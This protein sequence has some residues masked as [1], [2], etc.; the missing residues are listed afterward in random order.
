MVDNLSPEQRRRT[1]QAV[2]SRNTRLEVRLRSA[3]HAR[4]LR[5]R[6]H[7]KDL[8]GTPDLIFPRWN[9]VVFV[10][11]CFWHGHQCPKGAL[12]ATRTDYWA[13][14]QVKNQRRD[15]RVV[16]ELRAQGWRVRVLWE[17]RLTDPNR[18]AVQLEH[19]LRRSS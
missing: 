11:G 15:V 6:I 17:C 3:V 12:P 10:H 8:P 18:T 2:H 1:M 4:G 14:K 16:Q 5:F 7:G 13:Q 9:A 19:W